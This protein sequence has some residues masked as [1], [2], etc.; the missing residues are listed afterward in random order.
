MHGTEKPLSEIAFL[1][2]ALA[3]AERIIA[4]SRHFTA[5]VSSSEDAIVSKTLQGIVLS[6]NPAAERIFGYS[7]KEMVGRPMTT[8]FP[9]DLMPEEDAILKRVAKGEKIEHYETVRLHKSGRKV[10]VSV[11]VSPVYNEAGEVIAAAKIARD[12]TSRVEDEER[13]R[14]LARSA[15]HLAAIIQSSEDAI[16]SKGLDGVVISWNEGAER[17]FG[18]SA[19][20]MVGRQLITIFPPEK[21]REEEMILRKISEGKRVEHFR[22]IRIH[23]DGHPVHVSA[24][25]SPIEDADGNIIGISNIARDVTH[26]V[27]TEKLVWQQANFDALTQLPNRRLFLDRLEQ[28]IFRSRRDGANFVLM[29]IDLDGFKEVNDTFGHHYG[30]DLLKSVAERIQACV[31][32]SDTVARIGGDEFVI[33]LPNITPRIIERISRNL[34]VAMQ[35]PFELGTERVFSSMSL[36]VA[37]FPKDG[38]KS[39]DLMKHADQAM[40]EAKKAG[41]NQARYFNRS[42]QHAADRH[43][44]LSLDMRD[45]VHKQQLEMF[46]QPIKDINNCRIAKAEALIRWHHPALG[47]I[48]PAEFIPIAEENGLI[49]EI[50]VWVFNQAVAQLQQWQ[51]KFGADFQISINKSPLQFRAKGD[52]PMHWAK[53]LADAGVDPKSLIVELT[54]NAMMTSADDVMRK[55][56]Q[57]RDIGIQVAIDDFGTGYSSLS[58]L[59]RFDIDYLKI[60]KSFV[61]DIKLNSNEYHLCEAIT[62]MAHKL[63]LQVVAEGV[64]TDEQFNLL[65]QLGCDF[66]QGY[67]ISRPLPPDE[68]ERVIEASAALF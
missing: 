36:G 44:Q 39:E 26:L 21:F 13:A 60:D 12:I 17:I 54:E 1:K 37:Q 62:I 29:Y 61:K 7:S 40:Y 16:I 66:I 51:K 57:Y 42:M 8:V 32:E 41:K 15:Y 2:N 9:P 34:I 27:N 18:Y 35:T 58:Y 6:W 31:R 46:Y 3:E 52:N 63:G 67:L 23:K 14:A 53:A 47:L 5:I 55:L 59:N 25:I 11:T 64:E 24:T 4:Q 65:S 56:L 68:I 45:A 49:H 30:D 50:G 38:M 43:M 33:I 48:S 22:T 28:A 20:E 19:E 10:H